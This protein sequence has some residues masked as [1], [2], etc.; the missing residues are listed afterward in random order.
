MRIWNRIM[1]LWPGALACVGLL[2]ALP[3]SAMTADELAALL[4]GG[5]SIRIIDVR[6]SSEY[7]HN[8]IPGAVNVPARLIPYKRFPPLG[9]VVVYGSG[10]DPEVARDA[11][12][13]LDALQGIDAEELVG[14]LEAWEA[15]S[16]ADTSG[17]GMA[18]M[19]VPVVTYQ[20][21]VEL[22]ESEVDLVLIDLRIGEDLLDLSDT[23]PTAQVVGLTRRQRP[24]VRSGRAEPMV[25]LRALDLDPDSLYVLIDDGD[26]SRAEAVALRLEGGGIKRVAT[27][28]GGEDSIRNQGATGSVTTT[29]TATVIGDGVE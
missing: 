6:S 14:G 13:A 7:Q 15:R 26:L 27:L 4:D 12:D 9:R 16:F 22:A 29:H 11:T 28:G 8:H 1:L 21:L 19:G 18:T 3:A 25:A 10:L 23:F 24:R 17:A 5:E 2:L 20:K